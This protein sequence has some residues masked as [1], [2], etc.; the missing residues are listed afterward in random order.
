MDI[1]SLD[2]NFRAQVSE[3]IPCHRLAISIYVCLSFQGISPHLR[4][5]AHI[6]TR[7]TELF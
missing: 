4:T 2:M 7:L 6:G 3:F 5:G 1:L